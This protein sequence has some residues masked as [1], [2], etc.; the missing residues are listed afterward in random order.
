LASG[1]RFLGFIT[2]QD[3]PVPGDTVRAETTRQFATVENGF[4]DAA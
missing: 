2:A 4:E 3:L 1:H